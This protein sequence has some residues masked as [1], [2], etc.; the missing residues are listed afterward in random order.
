M[1]DRKVIGSYFILQKLCQSRN[2]LIQIPH[3]PV[4]TV[5]KN[6]RVLILIDGYDHP[7]LIDSYHVLN[8]AGDPAGHI[9]LRLHHHAGNPKIAVLWHPLFALRNGAGTCQLGSHLLGKGFHKGDLF[10]GSDSAAYAY[11]PFGPV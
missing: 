4:I 11:D 7:G 6:R 9:H 8:L 1:A 5:L 3:D 10:L 2:H